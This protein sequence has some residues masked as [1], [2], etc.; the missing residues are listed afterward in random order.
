MNI[1]QTEEEDKRMAV[2]YTRQSSGDIATGNT[3]EA[4]HL[5]DEYNKIQDT[6]H[7]TAGHTHDG[8][9][10]GGGKIPM[11]SAV[12]GILPIANGGTAASSASAART[13]LGLAIGS[14]VQA[15]TS[16]LAGTTAS[17]LTAQNTKVN[18][19]TVT[20]AVNLD[21]MESNIATNNAK[22]GIT[23]GQAS[24]ITANTA[25]TGITSGQANAI[26]ANTAKTGITSGQASAITANTAKTGITSGQANAIT[27]NTAKVTNATHTGDVTGATEL[28]IATGAVE[29]GMIAD[30]AV[31]VDK[32]ANSINSAITANTAKTGITSGQTSAI[33]A[34]TAKVTNATHSGEVTGSTAL[35]IA[36]NVV[37][38]P[39]LKVSNAPTN[40]YVLTAQSGDTGGLTWSAA[41]GVGDITAVVAGTGISGG[42]TSGSV[43][44]TN[45]APNVVQTTVSGNAGTATALATARTIGGT[46]FNGTANIAVALA[47]TATTLANA[48]TIAG[49]SFNGSANIS[50]NN[51]AITNGAGYL[52]SVN[53]SN[54][55]G[56][57]LAVANGGTGASDAGA[58][59]TALGVGSMGTDAKTV[60]TSA[61]S[62]TPADGDVWF[63]YTA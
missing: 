7:A 59:R 18:F 49:V 27:A 21:T 14:N 6:F 51:N 54:W 47:A 4:A 48:R 32:L 15:Y 42:G 52:A 55:S 39:K 58:A 5:N 35:T 56:T 33:T 16:V 12:S 23:S 53:N 62:G 13:A 30:D 36:N 22:T 37:D 24:A 40:G 46:S 31:T 11:A 45:S 19:L 17:F 3:I 26:V 8:T 9:T 28:T 29:T 43:T 2:G 1:A 60:S 44:I 38:E 57:D 25:K 10:G 34:N 41:G 50:L 61:A 20:Q 63:R